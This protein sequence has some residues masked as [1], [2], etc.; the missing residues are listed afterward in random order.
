MKRL[1]KILPLLLL[2]IFLSPWGAAGCG[3]APPTVLLNIMGVADMTARIDA[4]VV[5]SGRSASVAF[6]RDSTN[7][8][9]TSA[10]TMPAMLPSPTNIQLAFDLPASTTGAVKVTL[11]FLGAPM[12]Q[13]PMMGMPPLQVLQ[14]GCATADVSAGGLSTI[15]VTP[16]APPVMCP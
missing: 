11:S 14:I 7:S 13:M 1:A 5:N 12:Q 4:I 2:P 16:M 3:S 10:A 8:Y 15:P 9:T 6:Y